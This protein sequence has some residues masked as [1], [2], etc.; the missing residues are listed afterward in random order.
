MTLSIA[1]IRLP[2]AGSGSTSQ[3]SRLAPMD[4]SSFDNGSVP[5][6]R[7]LKL[8]SEPVHKTFTTSA[9]VVSY[10]VWPGSPKW[11]TVFMLHA[12]G[13]HARVWDQTIK[14]L[15]D[16]CPVIAAEMRGHGRSSGREPI[17]A[18]QEFSDGISELVDHLQLRDAIGVGHSM[19]GYTV[20]LTSI[21]R[22]NVF[23]EL[24]LVDPV[25]SEPMTYQT[26]PFAALSGLHDHP[27]A[28]R[29][30]HWTSWQ[31]MYD[32]L[33][34][35]EPYSFWRTEVLK[36]YCVYG[37]MPAEDGSGFV[38]ACPPILEASVYYNKW[39][40]GIHDQ[41]C[42]VEVPVTVLRARYVPLVPGGR[43]DYQRSTTWEGL[44]A[45]FPRGKDIYLPH[46]THFIPMQEPETV[47][48]HIRHSVER[49]RRTSGHLEIGAGIEPKR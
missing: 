12:T 26:N 7:E 1:Q 37:L 44:P 34:D 21:R 17:S 32:H 41:L 24:I 39:R 10:F 13:F 23:R 30:N 45:M 33:S 38:L 9:G 27:V 40:S 14:A 42:K 19:G 47:A 20:T 2:Q 36:D 43:S 22:P 46:L 49:V 28:R 5:P 11:P 31:D 8:R 25:I 6:R 29:R 35:R 16:D 48:H 4:S 15:P 18:W 3:T